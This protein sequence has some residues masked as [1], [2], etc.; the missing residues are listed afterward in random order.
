MK[1]A[2]QRIA[3]RF[4]DLKK[5]DERR[6]SAASCWTP[7]AGAATT[8]RRGRRSNLSGEVME[9]VQGKKIVF[10]NGWKPDSTYLLLTYRDEGDGGMNF[11]DYLRDSIPVEEEKMTH[12]HADEN[13][14]SMLM[15]GGSL[16]LHDGGYRDYM[17]SGPLR[18]LPAGLLPQP[19]V[20][21]AREDLDGTEGRA[22]S[23]TASAARFPAQA[24]ARVPPQRRLVPAGPHAEGGLPARCPSST[25]RRTRLIDDGWGYEADRVVVYVKDPEMFVVFDV[26]KSRTEEYFTLANLWH[27][28]QILA[29]GEHWYDTAYDVVG[30]E[31]P[32][33]T[34][35]ACWS[36]S[37]RPTSGW[38]ASSRRSG[39]TRTS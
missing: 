10:R 11:R 38:R 21:A 14:I 8:S 32:S 5:P 39:T 3:A 31:K 4:L 1:W 20:R 2:A 24:A 12:G 33:R 37:R 25:T 17:P 30:T 29:R 16:L 36:C 28:R 15:S 34:R 18:R 6:A 35:S 22:R 9:D 19:P 13:S 26:F 7:T 23:A 27:T